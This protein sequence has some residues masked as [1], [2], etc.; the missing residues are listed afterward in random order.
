METIT[1]NCVLYIITALSRKS[2][3]G[4]DTE[5]PSGFL[6][7][8]SF[9]KTNYYNVKSDVFMAAALSSGALQFVGTLVDKCHCSGETCF[10]CPLI[11]RVLCIPEGLKFGIEKSTQNFV[12]TG[13]I[14][15]CYSYSHEIPV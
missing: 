14:S 9:C 13:A 3:L 6:V 10:L 11:T 8:F 5:R 12:A 2:Y 4:S 7:F 15:I 1:L